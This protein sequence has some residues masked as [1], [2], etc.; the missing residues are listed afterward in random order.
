MAIHCLVYPLYIIRLSILY[1][2]IYKWHYNN[3]IN[4]YKQWQYSTITMVI[5]II[6]FTFITNDMG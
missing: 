6:L 3:G 5:Y 4:H 2:I 1:M